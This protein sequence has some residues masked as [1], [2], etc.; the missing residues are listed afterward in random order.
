MFLFCNCLL[1][2]LLESLLFCIILYHYY[3][4]YHYNFYCYYYYYFFINIIIIDVVAIC[5]FVIAV[6][7]LSKVNMIYNSVP[8]QCTLQNPFFQLKHQHSPYD[9]QHFLRGECSISSVNRVHKVFVVWRLIRSKNYFV[10]ES[11]YYLF[12]ARPCCISEGT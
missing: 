6:L 1:L 5:S 2:L 11:H 10:P 12:P 9:S 7:L 8:T 3:G 4:Y